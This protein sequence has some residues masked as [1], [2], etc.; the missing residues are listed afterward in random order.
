MECLTTMNWY[1]DRRQLVTILHTVNAQS[2]T[3][4]ININIIYKALLNEARWLRT[5]PE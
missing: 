1:I 2:V 3:I 5:T 4:I